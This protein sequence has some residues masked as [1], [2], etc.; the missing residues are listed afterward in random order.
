[1]ACDWPLLGGPVF[2]WHS[3]VCDE[4]AQV[5]VTCQPQQLSSYFK[6]QK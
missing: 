4:V 3:L 1:M 2:G 5:P 6:A